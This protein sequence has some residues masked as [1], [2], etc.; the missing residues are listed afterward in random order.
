MK[1]VP[2]NAWDGLLG[3][4]TSPF[5]RWDWLSLL[6]E[7][8]CAVESAGWVPQHVVLYRASRVIGACPMYMKLHSM[9]EFVFDHD[10][11]LFAERQGIEYYPKLLVGVPF[12][13]VTGPRFLT[14]AGED[15]PALITLMGQVIARLAGENDISSAHVNFCR[16]DESEALGAIGY[17][18]R[19]DVQFHW[20]NRGYAD[21]EAFL[22]DV[23]SSRRNKIR[24]ERKE[25]ARQ[26]ITVRAVEGNDVTEEIAG[27]LF[28]LYAVHVDNLY[29]GRR[30]LTRALFQEL[31][32]RMRGE[33]LP[34]LAER[35][36][37]T[38]AGTLNLRDGKALYGRYWGAFEQHRFLHFNVCYYAAIEA[39]IERGLSRFEAGAG[40]DFKQLR[41]LDPELTTSMHFIADS[42]FRGALETHLVRER[43]SVRQFRETLRTDRSQIKRVRRRP[44]S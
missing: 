40:G 39:C 7:T 19:N 14:A 42:R 1:D 11:A 35:N 6:E 12:T 31:R 3:E 43:E 2:R 4:G 22:G 25:L 30:Y 13:P 34:I 8:G 17:L 5:L 37:K 38:I 15:R 20:R 18:R 10:W 36:G 16:D 41:G 23:R 21:F 9:G 27:T 33:L 24:R 32:R 44:G 26:G 28:D 29:W